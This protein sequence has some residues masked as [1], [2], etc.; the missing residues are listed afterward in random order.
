[1]ALPG[2]A[3][4][5][6]SPRLGGAATTCPGTW[7][8][9]PGTAFHYPQVPSACAGAPTA[10]AIPAWANG[11]GTIDE[12]Q[13]RAESPAQNFDRDPDLARAP[14]SLCGRTAGLLTRSGL[15]K[16]RPLKSSQRS[17]LPN[18]LRLGTAA[19]RALS[20]LRSSGLDETGLEPLTPGSTAAWAVGPGWY[21][22]GLLAL[23]R[24]TTDLWVM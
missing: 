10:R 5:A 8:S 15:N 12:E 4:L 21:G 6:N 16:P 2:R 3:F 13:G 19:L 7:R 20:R 24:T 23:R 9:A 1:M 22:D 17:R 18:V 14:N 11:P